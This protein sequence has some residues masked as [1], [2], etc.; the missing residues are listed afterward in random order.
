M[1]ISCSQGA[2]HDGPG[3]R[4]KPFKRA[5][6][7]S[8][9]L[10]CKGA[11]ALLVHDPVLEFAASRH[12]GISLVKALV[13]PADVPR[14][15]EAPP[16]TSC[17]GDRRVGCWACRLRQIGGCAAPQ[18]V[19]E[20]DPEAPA[21]VVPRSRHFPC[22]PMYAIDSGGCGMTCTRHKS[23]GRTGVPKIIRSLTIASMSGAGGW[24]VM[25]R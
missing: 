10:T 4:T 5:L 14:D 9:R 3:K 15:C 23:A 11:P 8:L 17:T 20:A 25:R 19:R 7:E 1:M 18:T 6:S 22:R 13:W 24:T 12:A 2:L 21:E 16:R